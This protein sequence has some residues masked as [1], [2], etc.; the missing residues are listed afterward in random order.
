M[1]TT[2]AHLN[3]EPRIREDIP[4]GVLERLLKIPYFRKAYEPD[5]YTPDEFNSLPSLLSTYKEF[6]G[7]TEKMVQFVA[8]RLPSRQTISAAA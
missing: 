4:A 3:Y 1:F 7:A 2:G 5:G 8:E 6:S